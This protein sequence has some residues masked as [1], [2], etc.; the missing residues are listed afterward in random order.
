MENFDQH[1]II[2]I[3]TNGQSRMLTHSPS[4]MRLW[5]EL[6][7]LALNTSLSLMYAGA[8]ITSELKKGMNGKPLSK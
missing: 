7:Q 3:S 6:K 5:T 2:D 8:I 4:S 1:R